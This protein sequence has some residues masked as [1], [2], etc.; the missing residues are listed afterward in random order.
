[1]K[2]SSWDHSAIA[3]DQKLVEYYQIHINKKSFTSNA[4]A[5]SHTTTETNTK[6][7]ID[8]FV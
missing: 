3:L 6:L 1:M 5:K 4:N 2:G 8:T 7:N